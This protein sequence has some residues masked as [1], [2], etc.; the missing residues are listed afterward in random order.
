MW[1]YI[2]SAITLCLHLF[3]F[4]ISAF[5]Q[6]E[7]RIVGQLSDTLEVAVSDASVLLKNNNGD[8]ITYTISEEDGSFV[9][10]TTETGFFTLEVSHISF[11]PHKEQIELHESNLK[12]SFLVILK[13]NSNELG[14]V[15]I[16]AGRAVAQQDGDTLS[17]NLDAFTTGNEQ[18]LKDIINKLPGLEIDAHGN[19]KSEGK[20]IGNLLIDG[21]HFFGD[22]HKLAV[23]NLSA[24]MIE[25]ID[26]LKN[27][28][29]FD[30]VKDIEG[31]KETA[32]NIKIKEEYKGRP[33]G[34][35]DVYG[36]YKER[37]RS[38][39]NLF[40]FAKTHNISFIGDLNN[41]G[42]QSISLLDFIQMNRNRHIMDKDD[43]ENSITT[44][45]SI[46]AFLIDDH[47][48]NKQQSQFGAFN[49]VFAPTKNLAVEAFSILNKEKINERRFSEKQYYSSTS[50]LHSMDD[51]QAHNKHLINQTTINA[52]YKPSAHSLLNYS[53]EFKPNK[54]DYTTNI[55]SSIENEEQM[56]DQT[57]TIEGHVLGQRLEFINRLSQ[58]KLWSV[59]AFSNITRENTG[60]DIASDL[61]L[62]DKGDTISQ[63]IKNG[64][65]EYSIFSK[66][67]QR[68]KNHILNLNTGY[69]WQKSQFHPHDQKSTLSDF[70]QNYF[71][72]GIYAENKEG[73]LQYKTGINIRKYDNS[74]K[75]F[76]NTGKWIFLPSINSKLNFSSTHYLSLKY[77]RQAGF[78]KANQ[79][80]IFGYANSYRD[81]QSISEVQSDKTIMN[82]QFNLTYFYFNLFSGTQILLNS[83]YN[84]TKN[85]IGRNSSIS[86]NYNYFSLINTPYRNNWTTTM[87]F[88]TRIRPVKTI[89]KIEA[90]Y[91]HSRFENYIDFNR[92]KATVQN[93][94]VRPMLSS[95]FKGSWLNYEIGVEIHQNNTKFMAPQ[96]INKGTIASPFIN[97]N[98]V[99]SKNWM[100]FINNNFSYYRTSNTNRNMY[101]LDIEIRYSKE[102]SK[103]SYWL[104]GENILNL[105][106]SQIAEVYTTEN[107][108]SQNIIYQMPGY[109]GVGISYDF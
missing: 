16:Q 57:G 39:V 36:G 95:L 96:A 103:F 80:N 51:I 38:H 40:S 105:S 29:A 64:I 17:Y 34:N 53:F 13:P 8:I 25:G 87:Q 47:N 88:Q 28:E 85:I 66:Y 41:T 86:G 49:A 99:F 78:P 26:L 106:S 12:Y 5:S 27:Y 109:I 102:S 20:V 98:G 43:R 32:L 46:P 73:F 7:K 60:L 19:I 108:M 71:Y 74:F 107:S 54:N 2:C 56:T 82:N 52:E 77:T 58:N 89:F 92:N 21:K 65:R 33:T 18:K 24:E 10:E 81:F 91:T 59:N 35:I 90:S 94:Q 30:A 3:F 48:R 4:N 83:F 1:K 31:S 9:L 97:F 50:T 23:D 75:N 62:F 44:R 14:E 104:S 93:Y 76:Q 15:I 84:K 69:L 11:S 42:Q 101:K 55:Q 37:Y 6:S 72:T 68:T 70:R 100:Y 61:P 45:E 63:R 67:T 79:L 22:N